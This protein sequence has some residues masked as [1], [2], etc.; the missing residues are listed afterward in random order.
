MGLNLKDKVIGFLQSH[1]EEKFTAREIAEQIFAL[2]P[3]ECEAERRV[4]GRSRKRRNNKE[5]LSQ[6][7]SEIQPANWGFV[8]IK[9]TE[10]R[11]RKY[12][13][14][15]RSDN[16]EIDLAEAEGVADDNAGEKHNPRTLPESPATRLR[17]HDLYPLL[18]Q[19]LLAEFHVHSKR[20]DEKRSSNTRGKNGNRWLYPDV[21]GMENLSRE[22]HYEVRNCVKNYA[23]KSTKLWSFEVKLILNRS[24]VREC[25]FQAVSNSSWA[26]F[27]YLAAR[28]IS[29]TETMKELRLLSAAHGIGVIL[30]DTENPAESQVLIP[31]RENGNIDWDMVNRLVE[32]NSDFKQY[33]THIREFYQT[34]NLRD[35]D[36]DAAE[37]EED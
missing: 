25:F 15:L 26:N 9:S 20:I 6:I 35:K 18:S 36:W 31:A 12:Y 1:P 3:Q 22:W 7:S 11:P 37:T 24:N 29:G 16:E 5:L 19:Y 14:S 23:D 34:G 33:I 21:V 4:N 32:E 28:E 30:L 8:Q 13:Y 17:E 2:Y 10:G 27:G